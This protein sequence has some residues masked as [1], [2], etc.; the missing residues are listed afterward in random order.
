MHLQE[1]PK[2]TLNVSKTIFKISILKT[3]VIQL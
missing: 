2:S 3:T 1:M